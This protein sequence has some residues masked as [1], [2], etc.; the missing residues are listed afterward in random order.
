MLGE[1]SV[2]VQEEENDM[3][4][5]GMVK[6]KVKKKGAAKFKKEGEEEES[7]EEKKDESDEFGTEKVEKGDE[8]MAVKPW[9]GAI[10]QPTEFKMDNN[11]SKPPKAGL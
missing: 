11:L 1:S 3:S 2:A 10:K 7:K 8:F 5:I 6:E 4:D 9:L